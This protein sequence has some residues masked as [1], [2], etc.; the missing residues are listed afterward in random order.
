MVLVGILDPLKSR[1]LILQALWNLRLIDKDRDNRLALFGRE[2]CFLD[3][4][5]RAKGIG[6]TNQNE[7]CSLADRLNDLLAPLACSVQSTL[8]YPHVVPGITE[9]LDQAKHSDP[10]LARIAHENVDCT[11]FVMLALSKLNP[12]PTISP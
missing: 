6:R 2:A 12:G 1:Q 9:G 7:G 8:I 4:V 11:G 5:V 10:V 3:Y